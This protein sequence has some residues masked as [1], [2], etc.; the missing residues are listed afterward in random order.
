MTAFN[1]LIRR[2]VTLVEMM[3]AVAV[4]SIILGMMGFLIFFTA[5]NFHIIHR[6]S[7]A[8]T[9]CAVASE[10]LVAFMRNAA[11]FEP[12]AGD[13]ATTSALRRMKIAVPTGA[14]TVKKAV[15]A[16]NNNLDRLEFFSDEASVSFD[17]DLNPVGTA[18]RLFGNI[19]NVTF[20]YE[21]AFRVTATFKYEYTGF[22][23]ILTNSGNLQYGQFITDIIAKNHFMD[24]GGPQSYEYDVTT[25]G[26]ASL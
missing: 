25:S 10:N 21:T 18:D 9:S 26:P 2:G 12:Y 23:R 15:V 3:A 1:Y 20:I 24:Q 13:M 19:S 7:L 8:Q 14:T 17:G 6:Q 4:T 22:A 5:R 11:Y 16:Y